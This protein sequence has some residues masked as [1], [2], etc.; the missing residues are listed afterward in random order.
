[1]K[2]VF[3]GLLES[4]QVYLKF[5]EEVLEGMRLGRNMWLDG[6]SLVH[7]VENSVEE[8][9]SGPLESKE[10][11]RVLAVLDWASTSS[12][13]KAA[14]AA[15]FARFCATPRTRHRHVRHRAGSR[16]PARHPARRPRPRQVRRDSTA[17]LGGRDGYRN[18]EELQH[19]G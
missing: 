12:P 18:L 13:P 2:T 5:E 3:S 19:A 9:S 16:L 1:M 10:Y 14:R 8:M 4:G 17:V 15:L 7:M 11:E 6:R